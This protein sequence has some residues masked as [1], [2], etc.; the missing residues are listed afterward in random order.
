MCP[1]YHD[2]GG[3]NAPHSWLAI[4][5]QVAWW[6]ELASEGKRSGKANV[7]NLASHLR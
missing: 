6:A 3:R 7:L 2:T 4:R 5:G 1:G